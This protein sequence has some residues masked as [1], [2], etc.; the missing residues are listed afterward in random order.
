[1][2]LMLRRDT[3]VRPF[4]M[5]RCPRQGSSSVGK[6]SSTSRSI[7]RR[8][9]SFTARLLPGKRLSLLISAACAAHASVQCR[10]AGRYGNRLQSKAVWN[11]KGANSA[12]RV[13]RSTGRSDPDLYIHRAEDQPRCACELSNRT[14]GRSPHSTT[15]MVAGS[16]NSLRDAASGISSTAAR[17]AFIGPTWLTSTTD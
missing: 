2:R 1:M 7:R 15:V 4:G 17:S 5:M 9:D 13:R 16:R 10:S 12:N 11:R 14:S 8:H 3:R 6:T